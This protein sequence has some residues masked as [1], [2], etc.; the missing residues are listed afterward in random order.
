MI[1][2]WNEYHLPASL[3]DALELLARYQG[4]AR[5]VSGGTDL[6]LD[7]QEDWDSGERPHFDALVDVTRIPG[8]NTIREHAG[9]SPGSDWIE[10]GCGVTHAQVVESPL[11]QMRA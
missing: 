7:L 3:E 11:V 1:K 6:L 4:R 5:V 8:A 2:F 10:I 9:K